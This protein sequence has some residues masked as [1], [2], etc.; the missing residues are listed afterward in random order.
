MLLY[1]FCETLLSNAYTLQRHVSTFHGSYACDTCEKTFGD[2]SVYSNHR[3]S[4]KSLCK[5]CD[6]ELTNINETNEHIATQHQDKKFQCTKCRKKFT[7][8]RNLKKHVQHCRSLVSTLLLYSTKV[9]TF[10]SWT[11]FHRN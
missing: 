4:C 6:L 9:L 10:F 8:K 7:A 5:Y 2:L 1:H 11:M 3:H